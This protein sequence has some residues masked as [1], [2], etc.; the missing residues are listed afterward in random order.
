MNRACSGILFACVA[1]MAGLGCQAGAP[2]YQVKDAPVQTATGKVPTLQQVQKTIIEAGAKNDWVMAVVKPGEIRGTL[3]VRNHMAVVT[4]P[5]TPKQYSILY[6][7][8]TNLKYN[9]DR[10]T[11]HKEY[12]YWIQQLDN[13]I[14]AR[15]TALSN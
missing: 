11:I 13:D 5:F 12:T 8:S 15:L 10:Q 2:I 4:I 9:A 7:D 1:L 6:K 14:R 3:S